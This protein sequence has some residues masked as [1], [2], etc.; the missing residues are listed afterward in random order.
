M[1]ASKGRRVH[2]LENLSLISLISLA[3]FEV[4]PLMSESK[5]LGFGS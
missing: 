4:F 1:L 5:G 2:W 3:L